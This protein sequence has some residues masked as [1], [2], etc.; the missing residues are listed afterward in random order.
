MQGLPLVE[1][2]SVVT[3][4]DVLLGVHGAG[5]A[6]G[7]FL[8]PGGHVVEVAWPHE[9]LHFYYTK[10]GGSGTLTLTAA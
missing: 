6:W 3:C 8:R 7:S 9:Q 5:L 1:Q 2:V 4:C 10:S